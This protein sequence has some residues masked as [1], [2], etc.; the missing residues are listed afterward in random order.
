LAGMTPVALGFALAGVGDL[1]LTDNIGPGVGW[2]LNVGGLVVLTIAGALALSRVNQCATLFVPKAGERDE[3]HMI[4]MMAAA[5]VIGAVATFGW[6]Q[7]LHISGGGLFHVASPAQDLAIRL[8]VVTVAVLAA[9]RWFS[10]RRL[11]GAVL[12]GSAAVLL[13]G[14]LTAFFSTKHFV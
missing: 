13:A 1:V 6:A 11:K 9:W 8:L 4:V 2:L 14:V 5:L 3:I 7:V 10:A 12:L